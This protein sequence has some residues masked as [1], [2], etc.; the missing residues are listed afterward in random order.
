MEKI[1][2]YTERMNK[3]QSTKWAKGLRISSGVI[4]N[5]CL[6]FL[7][8]FLALGVFAA[9]VGAGYFASLVKEEPI[10]AKEDMR[11]NVF[12]YEETS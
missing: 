6:L 1:Q 9:S 2:F 10:R 8:I 7:V 5:L 11:A 4:W 3:W 12:N